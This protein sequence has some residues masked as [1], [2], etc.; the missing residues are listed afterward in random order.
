[1]TKRKDQSDLKFTWWTADLVAIEALKYSTKTE[2]QKGGGGAYSFAK[3]NGI[4]SSVCGHMSKK[5]NFWT[6]DEIKE[7]A[8]GFTTRWDFERGNSSAYGAAFRK[9]WLDVVC[10]HMTP[11]RKIKW[12]PTTLAVEA[13]KYSSRSGFRENCN[14]GYVAAC[15]LGI[16]DEICAHTLPRT[17]RKLDR[18]VYVVT[19]DQTT[20]AY[21]GLSHDVQKRLAEHV[22]HRTA[23]GRVLSS[24]VVS[25]RQVEG[26]WPAREAAMVESLMYGAMMENGWRM[27][28][29]CK[30][31]Q[32]GYAS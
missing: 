21:V 24:G 9:G 32:L 20:Q 28:N 11:G 8:L 25:Q 12:T 16:I 6:L 31:G 30:C 2:F 22:H 23:L 3:K 7:V 19:F 29:K 26:P 13:A 5:K 17:K 1:M 27:L 10:A 14:S 18:Y 4:L 15:N